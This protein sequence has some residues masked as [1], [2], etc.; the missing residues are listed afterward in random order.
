MKRERLQQ[1]LLV[2]L[3]LI[4]GLCY[5]LI[6]LHQVNIFANKRLQ[7][8]KIV[9]LSFASRQDSIINFPKPYNKRLTTCF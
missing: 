2:A 7:T 8:L 5:K 1:V 3:N 4:K 9:N 6:L